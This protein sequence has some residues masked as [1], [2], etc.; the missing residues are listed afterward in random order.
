MPPAIDTAMTATAGAP[1]AIAH[2]GATRLPRAYYAAA[3]FAP[4]L[5]LAVWGALLLARPGVP[6]VVRVGDPAPAFS[7]ADLDGNP[8]RLADLRGRPVIVNFWASWC[9]PCVEEFPLLTSAAAAHEADG[10]AI[11]GIVFQDR[12]EAAR[13][14]L[15]RMGAS[16]PAAMDPGDA[17]ANRFGIV[18]PPDTFF[19]D[20]N[21]VV[22]GRQIGQLSAADLDRGL[23]QIL[24]E[25]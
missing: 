20:R 24:G 2:H 17:I 9:G 25:E 16:W 22:V 4:L 1:G 8:I 10:L 11:V 23:A 18:G 6:M 12:S 5:I 15:A 7:L 3:A 21:G 19:I 14:F 13:A